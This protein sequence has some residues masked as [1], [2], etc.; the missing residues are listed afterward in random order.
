M[1]ITIFILALQMAF[2]VFGQRRSRSDEGN[3]PVALE[4]ITYALPRT[5]L[6]ITVKAVKESF[7]PGPYVAYAD[8][9]L[10]ITNAQNRPSVRWFIE[11]IELETFA[12]P[13]PEQVYKAL[14]NAAFLVDLTADGRL[15]G[16]NS[17]QTMQGLEKLQTNSFVEKTGKDDGFS[18]AGVSDIPM[19]APGDSTNNFRPV[20][21]SAERKAA[22]AAE[23]ILQCR[24]T[25]FHIA[26]GLLDEFH[27]DGEAYSVSLKELERMEKDYLSLFSG[28]TTRMTEKFSF[29]FVPVSA[30]DRGE[31]VFRFSEDKGVI[32][33]SDL[34]GKP[35]VV[36]IEPEKTLVS[37]YTALAGSENPA[38]GESGV[39]YRM[40]ATVNISVNF[41]L[42]TIATARTVMA[43]F[44]QVAPVPE[45]LLF[46]GHAIEIHPETGAVKSILKK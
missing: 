29:D 3:L 17:G 31:V 22:A 11:D 45:E 7:E 6:H 38:A 36:R 32:P 40:P 27:P 4:G 14:G 13:D 30:S 34:S 12:E 41:E 46:G 16:I 5:G 26:S 1:R 33:A 21:I 25:R 24:L 43:Q 10:G 39:Y 9:L 42:N 2:P 35:V 37:K 28:R 44:G 15:A 23:R 19:F 20:R 18:F 8:Q